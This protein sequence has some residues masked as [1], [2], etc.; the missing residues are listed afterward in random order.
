MKTN[1]EKIEELWTQLDEL[2]SKRR[3]SKASDEEDEDKSCLDTSDSD[4]DDLAP[5]K[6]RY[7][8]KSGHQI[9]EISKFNGELKETL[10]STLRLK[11]CSDFLR[12]QLKWS[13]EAS[14]QIERNCPDILSNCDKK[15]KDS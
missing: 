4:E 14:M 7:N 5:M 6:K 12:V 15:W 2:K 11:N 9:P 13:W 1:R 8:V 3:K 10:R